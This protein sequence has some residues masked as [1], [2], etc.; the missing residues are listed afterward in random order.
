MARLIL[1]KISERVST[2]SLYLVMQDGDIMEV[3]TSHS[4][5]AVP[6]RTRQEHQLPI[7]LTTDTFHRFD[8]LG[9]IQVTE[10]ICPGWFTAH[11]G[12]DISEVVGLPPWIMRMTFCI[13]KEQGGF[14]HQPGQRFYIPVQ[15]PEHALV[16]N[17]TMLP[18]TFGFVNRN[19]TRSEVYVRDIQ[20]SGLTRTQP[21]TPQ[22]AKKYRYF[23]GTKLRTER[24]I[25]FTFGE[26]YSIALH[27]ELIK[28]VIR[29]K[30]GS[31]GQILNIFLA[32]GSDGSIAQFTEVINE[33]PDASCSHTA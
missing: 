7:H 33:V 11:A 20:P 3:R 15:E 5:G 28:F 25:P 1:K 32:F 21:G 6:H 23:Q 8:V 30:M 4:R 17:D 13:G 9:G 24:L 29:E 22:Q 14:W 18:T 26:T 31:K 19:Y 2:T 12:P 16:Q 10:V 27:K